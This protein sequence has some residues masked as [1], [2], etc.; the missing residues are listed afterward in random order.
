M[1]PRTVGRAHAFRLPIEP[2]GFDDGVEFDC[3]WYPAS[4][5]DD[6]ADGWDPYDPP[7]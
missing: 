4:D 6:T 2:Q 3:Y 5:I 1:H 7:Y